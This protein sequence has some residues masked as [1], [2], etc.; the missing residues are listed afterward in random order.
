MSFRYHVMS[1]ADGTPEA[2]T[3]ERTNH[4]YVVGQSLTH[5]DPL[6]QNAVVV[7]LAP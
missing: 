1:F 2:L 3:T 7:K 6:D 4:I 5:G